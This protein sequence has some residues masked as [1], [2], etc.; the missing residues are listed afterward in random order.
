[1]GLEAAANV[2]KEEVC[3]IK[4]NEDFEIVVG[5]VIDD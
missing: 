5:L 3:K 4:E 2:A 1:M